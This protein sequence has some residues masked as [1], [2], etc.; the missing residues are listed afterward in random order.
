MK[1]RSMSMSASIRWVTWKV[2]SENPTARSKVPAASHPTRA[3]PGSSQSSG[4][5]QNRTWCRLAGLPST[6]CWYAKSWIRPNR[7]SGLTGAS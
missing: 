5:R 6:S 3:P 1:S 4:V 7:N 2:N